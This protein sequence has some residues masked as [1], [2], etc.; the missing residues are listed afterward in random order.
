MEAF[1]A[2]AAKAN[3]CHGPQHRLRRECGRVRNW[4][5]WDLTPCA[6]LTDIALIDSK[7]EGTAYCAIPGGRGGKFK[8]PTLTE[9]HQK[10]FGEGFGD[11]HDAAYD[12]A[13]TARCFFEMVRFGVIARPEFVAPQEVVYE[14]PALEKPPISPK[15]TL[16]GPKPKRHPRE[17]A[18]CFH[19]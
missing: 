12:V 13:A 10:L 3:L 15:R 6:P 4:C 11:A 2:D 18:G 19:S 17:K 8:W 1:M 9:L 5:A 14:A 16:Q 7:D